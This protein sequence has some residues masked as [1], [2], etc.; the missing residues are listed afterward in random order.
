M[1]YSFPILPDRE[2]LDKSEG[3]IFVCEASIAY[4]K[5]LGLLSIEVTPDKAA[6]LFA[7]L[8]QVDFEQAEEDGIQKSIDALTR[9][10]S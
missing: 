10:Q 4:D 9:V 7:L 3:L 6:D 8:K 2:V 5:V 1:Q